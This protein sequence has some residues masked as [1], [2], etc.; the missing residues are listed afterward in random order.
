M[1]PISR[2]L[3][4]KRYTQHGDAYPDLCDHIGRYCSYC[5]APLKNG[6]VE[7]V[8]PQHH[9]P[10]LALSWNNFLLGC[11]N[12]NATKG[13]W[14]GATAGRAAA[15]W[16]DTDNT[17]RAFVYQHGHPPTVAAAGASGLTPGRC[18]ARGRPPHSHRH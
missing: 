14:P 3:A 7:H 5:E 6:E 15:V 11:K 18:R 2:G 10:A 4:P 8:L 1:R 16:P 13:A 12:C 17:A 9:F